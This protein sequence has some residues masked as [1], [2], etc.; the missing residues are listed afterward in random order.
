MIDDDQTIDAG[1]QRGYHSPHGRYSFRTAFITRQGR[2]F[3]PLFQRAL[4][5]YYLLKSSLKSAKVK[6]AEDRKNGY[7]PIC[8]VGNAGTTNTGAVDPLDALAEFCQKQDLW[9]HVDA[10]YG[11]PAAGTEAVGRLFR[12]LDRADS[13]VVDRR[14][15]QAAQGVVSEVLGRDHDRRFVEGPDAAGEPRQD[16]GHVLAKADRYLYSPVLVSGS[17]RFLRLF[18]RVSH[19]RQRQQRLLRIQQAI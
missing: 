2:S 15:Y 9:F 4:T 7:H 5:C 14:G 13:V 16:P 19:A 17:R 10:A 8:V 3:L 1:L 18:G 6:V 11:G 12:G